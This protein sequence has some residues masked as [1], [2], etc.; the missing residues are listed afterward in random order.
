MEVGP[1]LRGHL[2]AYPLLSLVQ[3]R[4]VSAVRGLPVRADEDGVLRHEAVAHG[5]EEVAVVY[6][7]L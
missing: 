4:H 3:L 6:E 1:H 2:D 7:W 5:A